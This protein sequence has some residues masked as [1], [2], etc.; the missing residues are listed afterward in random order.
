MPTKIEGKCKCGRCIRSGAFWVC[1]TLQGHFGAYEYYNV[2]EGYCSVCGYHLA[3][4]GV[5]HRMV[6][7]DE[8]AICQR[9]LELLAKISP[10]ENADYELAQARAETE[11]GDDDAG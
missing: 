8:L 6:R 11:G 7:A 2:S 1:Q 4:D 10:L 5:A 9:T 3:D